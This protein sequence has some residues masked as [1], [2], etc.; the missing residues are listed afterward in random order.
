MVAKI[1]L[2][3]CLSLTL[4]LALSSVAEAQNPLRDTFFR[5]ADAAKAAAIQYKFTDEQCDI[6]SEATQMLTQ[7][8]VNLFAVRSSSPEEDLDGASFAGCQE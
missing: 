4:L 5:E 8:G 3:K 6:L 1:G 7:S 2:L